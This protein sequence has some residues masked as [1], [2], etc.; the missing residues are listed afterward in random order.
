MGVIVVGAGHARD[1]RVVSRPSR[2]WPAPTKSEFVNGILI[3][4]D[5]LRRSG[6]SRDCPG[7]RLRL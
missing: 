6:F 7:R 5:D 4:A 2:A 3:I 1:Q